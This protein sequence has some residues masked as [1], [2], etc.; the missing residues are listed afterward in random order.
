VLRVGLHGVDGVELGGT[1]IPTDE[2]GQLLVDYLGPPR[3][4]PGVS[5]RAPPDP[6][7]P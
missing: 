7:R 2:R 4:I 3:T 1:L 5:V 6:W